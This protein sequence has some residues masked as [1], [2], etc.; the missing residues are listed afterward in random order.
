MPRTLNFLGALLLAFLLE[1]PAHAAPDDA[2]LIAPDS[3]PWEAQGSFDF[4]TDAKKT[5]RSLSGV[6]CPAS[7]SG[8]RQC[9]AAFDEGREA[10]HL[11]IKDKLV[12]LDREPVVLRAAAGE[13]DAEAAATDGTFYY[14]AGSHSAK[15][16]DCANNPASRAV[17]RFRLDAAT[18]RALRDPAGDPKG[19]LAGRAETGALWS[20][21]AAL[22]GLKDHVG[23]NMCL[24]TEAPEEGPF[25]AGRRGV[26]I[27]GLAVKGGRLLFGFRG[28]ARDGTAR[29]LGVDAHELFA[30]GA[31]KPVLSTIRVG[32]G[33]AIRDLQT[34]SDGIL[35]L[36]GPDDDA[37]NEKAGWVLL[38]WDGQEGH[39]A[40]AEPKPLAR[41]DLSGV[42]LRD[43]DK[44][45]KPEAIAV[46][47][48]PPA[49][50]RVIV[51]SDGM[52]DGGPLGFTIA[53]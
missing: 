11:T 22:P 46:E 23:D 42:Q 44:E 28:P 53:R 5:R 17:I 21:M 8:Q 45:L 43:C 51:F 32:K 47:D 6:A 12:V 3:G 35:V 1:V 34:V 4:S 15:R 41:L 37:A 25:K 29:I 39:G 13:L 49:K 16:K 52:C 27:E 24:G 30:G 38:R 36:A 31:A 48:A 18:G 50:Y 7:T 9:L 40:V 2:P 33:R 10:R 19:E 20:I 26:N 14:L